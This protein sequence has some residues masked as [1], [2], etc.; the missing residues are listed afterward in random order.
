MQEA[1]ACTFDV[2]IAEA[3]ERISR[4]MADMTGIH[5]SLE[6]RGIGSGRSAG[7]QAYGY[8]LITGKPLELLFGQ[9]GAHSLK[10][11]SSSTRQRTIDG[12]KHA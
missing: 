12:Q 2:L 8:R 4:D 5:E 6:F 11:L 3:P 9:D 7:G 1:E 10:H